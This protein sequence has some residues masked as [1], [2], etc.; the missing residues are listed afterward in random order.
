MKAP[1]G[2]SNGRA[3]PPRS[4]LYKRSAALLAFERR[5]CSWGE[6]AHPPLCPENILRL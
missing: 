6:R 5:V 1:I 2:G 3:S 4:F